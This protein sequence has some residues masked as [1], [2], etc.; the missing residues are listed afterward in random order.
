MAGAA[1]LV[2][3]TGSPTRGPD[4]AHVMAHQAHLREL[5]RL[6]CSALLALAGGEL[7]ERPGLGIGPPPGAGLRED[8]VLSGSPP[9][10]GAPRNIRINDRVSDKVFEAV[11]SE[12]SLATCESLV[13]AA[14]NDGETEAAPG[15]VG[16]G[17]SR[18]GGATWVDGGV[19]PLGDGVAVYV[20]D[21]VVAVNEKTCEFYLA[22]LAAHL[23]GGDG[24]RGPE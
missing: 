17:Y 20:S 6:E 22:A 10:A 21:P 13:V 23:F 5:K 3:V 15:P 8:A 7:D 9:L 16:F 14:W 18:D 24:S 4:G 12:V 11:Q 2:A 19:L 1:L